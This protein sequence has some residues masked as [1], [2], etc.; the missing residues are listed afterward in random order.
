MQL[1]AE[2]GGGVGIFLRPRETAREHAATTRWLVAPARGERT[3]QRWKIQLIHGHGGRIEK[4]LYLEHCRETHCI[5]AV[6]GLA[7]RQGEAGR[8]AG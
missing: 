7:D 8:A 3:L 5:R 2:Q 6:D 4:T 1:S